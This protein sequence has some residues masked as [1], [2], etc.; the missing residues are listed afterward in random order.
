MQ[1]REFA[2]DFSAERSTK[3]P[4]FSVR[5][6]LGAATAAAAF[7]VPAV[8]EHRLVSCIWTMAIASVAPACLAIGIMK[9][10]SYGRSFCIGALIPMALMTVLVGIILVETITKDHIHYRVVDKL[11]IHPN[12]DLVN[13]GMWVGRQV[14]YLP[15]GFGIAAALAGFAALATDVVLRGKQHS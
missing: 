10:R 6:L 5:A 3:Y 14:A 7:F 9:C 8:T 11:P 15:A 2:G 4:T 13:I 1:A 12:P